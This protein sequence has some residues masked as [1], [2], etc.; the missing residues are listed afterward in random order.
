MTVNAIVA[1]DE[2]FG[3]GYH[4]ELLFRI[5]EDMELFKELTLNN[6]VIMGRN[7]LE[8]LPNGEPLKDRINIVLTSDKEKSDKTI[9]DANN[10]MYA[11]SVDAAL[12]TASVFNK[13]IFVIG[14]ASVYEQMLEYCDKVYITK[15]YINCTVD[16][17]FPNIIE[18]S[19]F[20]IVQETGIKQ[21]NN[22]SYKL[23]VYENSSI[24]KRKLF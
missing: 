7:T 8:S 20:K 1:V 13:D 15:A 10:I 12:L 16:K 23:C 22:I 4:N 11:N 17:F 18:D 9:I 24:S 19:R 5:K 3:I 2:N 6:V 21:Y 14:G